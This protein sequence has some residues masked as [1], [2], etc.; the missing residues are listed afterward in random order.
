MSEPIK[1]FGVTEVTIA[2][3][4]CCGQEMRGTDYCDRLRADVARAESAW[5]G[6]M[7]ERDWWQK[8]YNELRSLMP[9][10]GYD[11]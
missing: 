4:Q 6:A 11:H 9:L 1:P 5:K 2:R 8:K 7:E 10:S 3:C